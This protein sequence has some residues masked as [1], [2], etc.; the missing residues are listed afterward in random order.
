[1]RTESDSRKQVRQAV[2]RAWSN[3]QLLAERPSP[4][5]PKR[6]RTR[7]H[8]TVAEVRFLDRRD[9][10]QA[11]SAALRRAAKAQFP[12]KTVELRD[13]AYL[14]AKLVV[15]ERLDEDRARA[16]L[17]KAASQSGV[18]P[19]EG[20]RVIADAY[21]MGRA[22][23]FAELARGGSEGHPPGAFSAVACASELYDH[24]L[25]MTAEPSSLL[26]LPVAVLVHAG[27][28]DSR[29]AVG[30]GVPS[31]RDGVVHLDAV[32]ASRAGPAW[33]LV[34]TGCLKSVSISAH[35]TE[36]HR[37]THGRLIRGILTSVD[38]VRTPADEKALIGDV[39]EGQRLSPGQRKTQRLLDE[40]LDDPRN[41][42]GL[43]LMADAE[44]RGAAA[45]VEIL[46]CL[47][48]LVAPL[49][50]ELAHTR[51]SFASFP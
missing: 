45:G 27:H 18:G 2:E 42:R 11:W 9:L 36:F 5:E 3:Y 43:D 39:V 40:Y 48:P 30:V 22:H 4:V 26:P 23:A 7:W 37:G 21:L 13:A 49:R 16:Y 38:L 29:S 44:R 41:P 6:E 31:Y 47:A 32:L 35:C 50:A 17:D 12:K 46:D 25:G 28:D 19:A 20:K 34:R 24:T 15:G 33:T 51:R 1:M 10:H 14:A 8:P